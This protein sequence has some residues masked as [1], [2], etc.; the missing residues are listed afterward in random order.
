MPVVTPAAAAVVLPALVPTAVRAVATRGGSAFR[1]VALV[2]K[3]MRFG[4]RSHGRSRLLA[5]SS[6]SAGIALVEIVTFLWTLETNVVEGPAVV[7]FAPAGEVSF[8]VYAVSAAKA[9]R[10]PVPILVS[11]LDR[12]EISRLTGGWGARCSGPCR[13]VCSRACGVVAHRRQQSTLW[14]S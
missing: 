7:T 12:G 14:A 9:A 10:L 4:R 11:T 13:A 5:F 3:V 6:R 8:A 2:G 1:R